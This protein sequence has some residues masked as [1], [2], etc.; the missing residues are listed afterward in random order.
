MNNPNEDIKY[1]I[2]GT[3]DNMFALYCHGEFT[4]EFY[5]YVEAVK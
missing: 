2:W 5:T 1:T 4:G 3:R